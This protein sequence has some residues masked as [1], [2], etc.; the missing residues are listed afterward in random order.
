MTVWQLNIKINIS[1]KSSNSSCYILF[2][3]ARNNNTQALITCTFC[4]KK[5]NIC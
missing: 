4:Q 5:L 3:H 1:H 2:V